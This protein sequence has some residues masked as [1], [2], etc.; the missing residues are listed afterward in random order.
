MI[1]PDEEIANEVNRVR[2]SVFRKFSDNATALYVLQGIIDELEIVAEGVEAD[3]KRE[4]EVA[5]ATYG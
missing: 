3:V 5:M 2:D 1:E 4:G